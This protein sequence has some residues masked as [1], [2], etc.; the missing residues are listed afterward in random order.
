MA[1]ACYSQLGG[2]RELFARVD[3]DLGCNRKEDKPWPSL[4]RLSQK[5]D[6][7]ARE[8]MVLIDCLA[9]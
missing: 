4:D 1:S 5:L 9:L 8:N 2:Y 6:A 7:N 3:P